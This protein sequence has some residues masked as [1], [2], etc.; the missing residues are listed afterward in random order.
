MPNE[1]S[2]ISKVFKHKYTKGSSANISLT[3]LIVPEL[4]DEQNSV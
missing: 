2:E 4:F 1:F 3:E